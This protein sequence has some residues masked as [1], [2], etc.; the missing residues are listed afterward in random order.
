ML[1]TTRGIILHTIPYSDKYS[2]VH[3]YT[4]VFGRISYLVARS[5]KRK[6]KTPYALFMPL[7]IIEMEVEH[8]KTREI[9]R[10]KE[11]KIYYPLTNIPAHPVKN[12]IAL[13]L[14]ET[15]YRI[16]QTKETDMKLFDY[17]FNSI[18]CLEITEQ[19]IAN[20]HLVFLIHLTRYLG[21]FPNAESYVRHVF[22]DL[23]NGVFTPQVPDHSHYLNKEESLIF[24]RL[25]RLNYE[26]MA[27][28]SFSRK[29]RFTI[30]QHILAYYRLHFVD[31]PE[32]KSLFVLQSLFE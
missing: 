4:E 18:R 14:A 19:G 8:L 2:I 22:F 13:F 1:C 29:E 16:I 20:F 9:Q 5:R 23:L 26:N 3:A 30:I 17:L 25:L 21:I 15:L 28:Y 6:T 10:L 12:A 11:A 7:S 27:L 31:F 24:S 32:I